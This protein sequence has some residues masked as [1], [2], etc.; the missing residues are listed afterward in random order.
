VDR[1]EVSDL[2]T[3][4][5]RSTP[6]W[7]LT[8]A[9]ATLAALFVALLA[10][11]VMAQS[12]STGIDA[13]LA[14]GRPVAAPPFRLALL[15]HG[16][17]GPVLGRRLA[18]AL[19]GAFLTLGALRGTPVVL[20]FYASWCVTCQA[21]ASTIEHAWR[22]LARPRGVLVLGLGMQDA[23]SDANAYGRRYAI[24]YPSVHDPSNTVAQSYGVTGLPETFFIDAAGQLVGHIIGISTSTQ[25]ASGIASALAGKVG[26]TDRGGAQR[27]LK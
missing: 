9:A 17:L 24:D 22:L 18:S 11:G 1:T 12:P 2:G 14:R 16:N 26:G 19:R 15:S 21:E 7:L 5:R 3:A 13:S 8:G 27:P 25:L 20:N 4:V 6:R 23:S 10:Y